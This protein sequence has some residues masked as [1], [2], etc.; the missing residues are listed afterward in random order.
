MVWVSSAGRARVRS[1]RPPG[2]A[3]HVAWAA[4]PHVPDWA[5]RQSL[6]AFERARFPEDGPA[7]SLVETPPED[8]MV[9][10]RKPQLPVR[11]ND[12]LVEYLRYFRDGE[13]GKALMRGWLRRAGRYEKRLRR[14][15][16]EV[17]VPEDLVF[18]ALAESGFNPRV[19]S[20]VG[21][22]GLWQF[23][24]ATG[25]VYGL[26]Q[27]FWIDE[28]F[29]V[30]KS[31]YA[32]AAYLADLH[33]RFGSWE[34]ALAAYNGGYGLVMTSISRHNTNN[35]WALASIESGLPYASVNYVPK[36][37]AAALVGQNREA[38]GFGPDAVKPDAELDW[39][40]VKLPRSTRLS[41]LAR[42][43]QTDESMLAEINGAFVR[44]RTPPGHSTTVR[45]PR[46]KAKAFAAARS[47]LEALW[48]GEGTVTVKH[49]EKLGAVAKRH[50]ISERE[51]RALNGIRDSA[52]VHGGVVLVVPSPLPERAGSQAAADEPE[53]PPLAAVPPLAPGPQQQLAFFRANRAS[54]PPQLERALGVRWSKIVRWNDLDPR[55]RLQDG[56]LLQLLL[57]E[58]FDADTRNVALL[59]PDQ[60]EHVIRGSR[61]HIEA[62]LGRRGKRRR[63]YRARAGDSLES[64]GKRFD[65]TVGDLSRINAI[66]RSH[67]LAPGEVLVVY[68]APGRTKGTIRAP[69]PRGFETTEDAAGAARVPSTAETA[70]VPG[71]DAPPAPTPA[72][73]A[74]TDDEDRAPS[75]PET[76]RVPGR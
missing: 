64:I 18:V 15:L 32:A 65:L 25:N 73:P 35:F 6:A 20:R 11:W 30:E 8:W 13:Q 1:D 5:L 50:G 48:R 40:E 72:E 29:D 43:L 12:R 14:I 41:D 66:S 36:I 67:A 31:S 58:G 52:E 34:L 62:E 7:P 74:P 53:L 38:M 70:R 51:L 22:A 69:A 60:V 24:E 57:P 47:E 55:A 21:A 42:L 45:I 10:L 26:Q 46:D 54:T 68:V 27:D 44:G 3:L 37:V 75:T 49:G 17:G 56:Q 76:A 2:D 39:V 23:M 19:R 28:R 9:D 33:A 4:P 59:R 61:A 63:G 16:G 71:R